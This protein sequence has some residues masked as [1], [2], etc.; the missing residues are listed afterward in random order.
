M[1]TAHCIAP[2]ILLA[3]LGLCGCIPAYHLQ[4]FNA[5]MPGSPGQVSVEKGIAEMHAEC[6]VSASKSLT[7]TTARTATGSYYDFDVRAVDSTRVNQ[8]LRFPTYSVGAFGAVLGEDLLSGR[9]S[10]DIA[11]VDG[12][13]LYRVDAGIGVRLYTDMLGARVFAS[14]GMMNSRCDVHV[15]ERNSKG[16]FDLRDTYEDV[17][18]YLDFTG[19]LNTTFESL[20]VNFFLSE[21]FLWAKLFKYSGIYIPYY[22]ITTTVGVYR[23]IGT[24]TVTAGLQFSHHVREE[25]LMPRIG[26]V[27]QV[28]FRA[29]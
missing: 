20:P 12:K 27:S 6:G 14:L 7:S 16:D 28:A 4:E 11:E 19:S 15:F 26:L 29:F 25:A 22:S 13:V 17:I 3:W 8:V 10:V 9:M 23:S 18:P 2:L 5:T 21:S 1:K 24:A